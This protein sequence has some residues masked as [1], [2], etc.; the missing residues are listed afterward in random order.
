[1]LLCRM[2]PC[3]AKLPEGFKKTRGPKSQGMPSSRLPFN[4]DLEPLRNN[5]RNNKNGLAREL[6]AQVITKLHSLSLI[7]SNVGDIIPRMSVQRLLQALLIQVMPDETSR[8]RQ[9]EET[10]QAT[11]VDQLINL[12]VLECSTASK[13]V[14]KATRNATIH[15]QN[16]VGL[17][18]SCN[19]LN[20][21]CEIQDFRFSKMFQSILL[22][23]LHAHVGICFTFDAVADTHD[24]NVVF[25]AIV[26]ELLGINTTIC[27]LREHLCSIV[28][29]ASKSR[30]NGQ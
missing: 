13:H 10:I 11:M 24:E 1:M 2:Q 18:G 9:H 15:I 17:F 6:H 26:Y 16:E 30:S 22:D 27:R 20:A 7:C 3:E 25:F 23:Q 14:N 12:F 4:D 19:L 29:C 28:Q 21:Q 8:A 5:G